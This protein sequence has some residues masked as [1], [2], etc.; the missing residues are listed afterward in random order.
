MK[1]RDVIALNNLEPTAETEC[2]WAC[3][4]NN[5]AGKTT[6]MRLM[7]YLIRA[8]AERLPSTGSAWMDL[9]ETGKTI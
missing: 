6:M 3:A 9:D 4:Y 2:W 5:G 8:V 1:Y 7:L